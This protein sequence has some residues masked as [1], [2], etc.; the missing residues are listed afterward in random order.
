MVSIYKNFVALSHGKKP[1]CEMKLEETI[2]ERLNM[3][4]ITRISAFLWIQRKRKRFKSTKYKA[5]KLRKSRRRN[6]IF[7]SKT[8][9]IKSKFPVIFSPQYSSV[10]SVNF[11]KKSQKK[12]FPKYG[13]PSILH[14]DVL[15][16]FLVFTP[17]LSLSRICFS[18]Y[19]LKNR[20]YICNFDFW[21][22]NLSIYLVFPFSIISSFWDFLFG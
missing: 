8:S 19:F 15:I 12:V 5:R 9:Q 20:L 14:H 21:P 11:F 16:Q 17:K 6:R 2:K 7:L 13:N 3:R 22:S 18:L 10:W 1:V 4:K